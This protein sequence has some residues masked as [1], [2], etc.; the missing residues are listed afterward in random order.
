MSDELVEALKELRQ[1]H[2]FWARCKA[3]RSSLE[4][5][6]MRDAYEWMDTAAAKVLAA[7]SA[8]GV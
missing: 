3:D 5:G 4:T 7:S 2:E 8:Y 6:A 1:A